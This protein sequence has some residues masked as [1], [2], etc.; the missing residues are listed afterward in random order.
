MFRLLD[1]EG[2]SRFMDVISSDM[3]SHLKPAGSDLP[4]LE[5]LVDFLTA[6]LMTGRPLALPL[7]QRV[8][9]CCVGRAVALCTL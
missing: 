4:T 6:W 9:E 7:V 2:E 5:K 8:G 1:G 3:L